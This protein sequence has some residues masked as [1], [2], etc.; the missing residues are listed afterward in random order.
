LAT[1]E[2]YDPAT[3]TWTAKAPM[4]TARQYL[5]AGVIN[6]VLYAVGGANASGNLA[7]VEGYDPA[8]STWAGKAPMQ[9][10]RNYLAA[11]VVS[12]LLYAVG[13]FAGGRPGGALA[14]VEAYTP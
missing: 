2:A 8:T 1:V 4:P 9:T 5:A 13:A 7:T 12:G 3:D 6:G 10:A 11:D 14:T